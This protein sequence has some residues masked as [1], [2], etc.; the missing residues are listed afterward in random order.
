MRRSVLLAFLP[1]LALPAWAGQNSGAQSL[2]ARQQQLPPL[3][4]G[5]KIRT[6][7][8]SHTALN[9]YR[10][11][12]TAAGL[13]YQAR[14]PWPSWTML[15]D[16]R[17][18]WQTYTD[19]TTTA[20]VPT[21]DIGP[22]SEGNGSFGTNPFISDGA[23]PST[24]T[25]T[26]V[27]HSLAVGVSALSTAGTIFAAGTGYA[28]NDTITLAPIGGIENTAAVLGVNAVAAGVVTA[29]KAIGSGSTGGSYWVQPGGFT[30]AST[31]GSGTGYAMSAPVY[32]NTYLSG[33]TLNAA[34]VNYAIGDEITL[35]PTGGTQQTAAR[36]RVLTLSGSAVATFL[37]IDSGVFAANPTAYSQASTTGV[38][39]GLTLSA[40]VHTAMGA[41][42]PGGAEYVIAGATGCTGLNGGWKVIAVPSPNT[43]KIKINTQVI[44]A[45]P[46]PCGGA[47]ATYLVRYDSAVAQLIGG[48]NKLATYGDHIMGGLGGFDRTATRIGF[49]SDGAM[50]ASNLANDICFLADGANDINSSDS[51]AKVQEHTQRFVTMA[52]ARGCG[53][54]FIS[55][56]RPRGYRVADTM[57]ANPITTT[58]GSA[59]VT[60]VDPGHYY[61][62]G[63]VLTCTGG[64][65]TGGVTP[66]TGTFTITAANFFPD[67]FNATWSGGNAASN[68]TG[69]GSGIVCTPAIGLGW[70]N[71]ASNGGTGDPRYTTRNQ[72]NQWVKAAPWPRLVT[73]LDAD[74]SML[75]TSLIVINPSTLGAPKRL[76]LADRA[77][78]SPWGAY[79][80]AAG[81]YLPA[82]QKNVMPAVFLQDPGTNGNA[83]L[84]LSPAFAATGGTAGTGVTAPLPNNWTAAR[85]AGTTTA[86]GAVA[87]GVLSLAFTPGAGTANGVS[88]FT[89]SMN[90]R[91]PY[92]NKFAT[93]ALSSVTPQSAGASPVMKVVATSISSGGPTPGANVIFANATGG[94]AAD[95][96]CRGVATNGTWVILD[97]PT[98]P[99][100]SNSSSVTFYYT[101]TGETSSSTTACTAG[102]AVTA[103]M[104]FNATNVLPANSY[105]ECGGY[106][107]LSAWTHKVGGGLASA[108]LGSGGTGYTNGDVL[109][110]VNVGGTMLTAP[111]I[112][113]TSVSV[114]VITGFSVTTSG[115]FAAVA[116]SFTATGGTGAN[117][118]F[119]SPVNLPIYTVPVWRNMEMI[120]QSR[121]TSTGRLTVEGGRPY[122]TNSRF[123]PTDAYQGWLRTPAM[124]LDNEATYGGQINNLYPFFE[125]DIED[126]ATDASLNASTGTWTLTQPYCKQVPDPTTKW[127][128]VVPLAAPPVMVT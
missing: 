5:A 26:L 51:L 118:T 66:S 73:V 19:F 95:G 37:I 127:G 23:N 83:N 103:D 93:K 69:G 97:T 42:Y 116:T 80:E 4:A 52:I 114:G 10:V 40:P 24:I 115:K 123:M 100:T 45:P 34:G 86:Q 72:W 126:M 106:V 102:T 112:T 68:S 12:G 38:G 41:G 88:T 79:A 63:D 57:P 121:T 59:V 27:G 61:I 110:L 54:V 17:F 125:I 16:P 71:A 50:S 56:V 107:S 94:D 25:V 82:I 122:S 78:S 3:A 29:L 91:I 30:Q 101:A 119:T 81:S 22:Y 15:I 18:D 64:S 46:S 74:P 32:T 6:A 13:A 28:T 14:S 47:G 75:D 128:M 35:A 120:V 92:F 89:A 48:G 98:F 96:K 76:Y 99:I 33:A 21:S 9:D 49:P 44:A 11:G 58:S 55:T 53:R 20:G 1:L 67:Q 109:T 2:A 87:S 77:H 90:G 124:R 65:A 105:W 43:F 104:T 31:S 36:I 70:D 85:T 39:S 8:D 117:A 62:S 7:A 108:T 113:V 111:T 84:L 60:F